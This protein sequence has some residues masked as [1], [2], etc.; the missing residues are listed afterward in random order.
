MDSPQKANGGRRAEAEGEARQWRERFECLVQLSAERY[1]E[2]DQQYRFTEI[3][4]EAPIQ[5]A[6]D[7][8]RLIGTYLW[9]DGASPVGDG[10]SWDR[11]RAVL[12]QR[13]PFFDLRF[14]RRNSQGELRYFSA[15]GRPIFDANCQFRGYRGIERDITAATRAR[16]LQML[17]HAIS[18]WISEAESVA[19]AVTAVMR[20]ICEM[21]G[22]EC[23]R[24]FYPDREAGVL[25]FGAA[26]GTSDPAIQGF[27]QRS[28]RI[29]F[30]AG[31]GL[32]GKVWQTDQPLWIADVMNDDRSLRSG[33]TDDLGV[34]GAFVFP[35]LAGGKTIAVLA[36]NSRRSRVPDQQLLHA[37]VAIGQQIGQYLERKRA[38]EEHRRFRAAID[39]SADLMLLVDRASMRYVD[40]NNAAL[41]LLG[42]TR[43]ELLSLRPQ[44]VFLRSHEEFTWLY[45]RMLS[46]ELHVNGMECVCRCKDGTEVPVEAFP[47]PM[48]SAHGDIIVTFARD[49]RERKRAE[50][51]LRLEHAITRCLAEASG[52]SDALVAAIRAVCE[53]LGWECGRYLRVDEQSEL[54]RFCEAWNVAGRPVE[55][56]IEASRTMVYGRGVGVVGRVWQSGEPLWVADITQDA[57]VARSALARETGMHAAFAIAVPIEGKTIGVLIFHSRQIREPD[58]RLLQAM[59]VIASQIGQFVQR[60]Q[61]EAIKEAAEAASR[62]KSQ[63]LAT[64]SHEI[65]TPMNGILGMTELLLDTKLDGAQRGYAQVVQQ[66]AENLL[67]IINDILDL[68]K[69]EAG[70]LVLEEIEFDTRQLFGDAAKLIAPHA[71]SKGL[72]FS[73]EVDSVVPDVLIG[74]ANRLRQVVINLLG[75]A[76]KFTLAGQVKLSV[77]WVQESRAAASSQVLHVAVADSGIGLSEEAMSRVFDAFAQADNSM[78]RRFG[79]TG[80]GLAI[81]KQ[82]VEAMG[83]RIGAH[84]K[85]GDGSTFWFTLPTRPGTRPADQALRTCELPADQPGPS[86]T[87]HSAKRVLVAEDNPVN[88]MLAR[89]MLEQLGLAVSIAK[90][91]NAAIKEYREGAFDIVLM[92]CQMPDVDGFQATEA[93]RKHEVAARLARVPIIALTANAMQGDRER[94][95]AAGMDDYLTKPFKKQTLRSCLIN[96]LGGE[97]LEQG[98]TPGEQQGLAISG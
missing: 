78:A 9:D 11:H 58:D 84:S 4:D 51:L 29:T 88:Q 54:L 3:S 65:R 23:G 8:K 63:F 35:V 16:A 96:W 6:L 26:W 18:D 42:Y 10:G 52:V 64:M 20:A 7:R 40:A 39:A 74:D 69:I 70:R 28:R 17:E 77:Q 61:T 31:H 30:E 21:E 85:L 89:T 87:R 81:C 33:F 90:D 60:K 44:D 34:R 24:Y 47:R 93:I 73:C 48:R 66:S 12:D 80:L 41:R 43:E 71:S 55:R 94:C 15:S 72:D 83:G 14:T 56:Y 79:G 68:S 67:C 22:W 32:I 1:W 37:I 53:N 92:D 27:I 59:R 45:D 46:G 86:L 97:A 50:Q 91:G 2:Q 57:R 38:E 98:V 13:Q 95:I 76:V 36:F 49:I 82:L 5:A 75:N 62:A 19:T 25:R